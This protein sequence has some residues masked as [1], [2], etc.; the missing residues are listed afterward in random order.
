MGTR[1]AGTVGR[2]GRAQQCDRASI[3]VDDPGDGRARGGRDRAAVSGLVGGCCPGQPV[4]RGTITELERY[5]DSLSI[6]SILSRRTSRASM[7][8]KA[9]QGGCEM[10]GLLVRT[11]STAS[12]R[13]APAASGLRLRWRGGPWAP[14]TFGARQPPDTPLLGTRFATTFTGPGR[15]TGREAPHLSSTRHTDRVALDRPRLPGCHPRPPE[16]PDRRGR[17]AVVATAPGALLALTVPELRRLLTRLVWR[18]APDPAFTLAWS[19]W[20]HRHQA[21][22]R[23]CHHQRQRTKL[24]LQ[25]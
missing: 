8:R 4:G 18:L 24:Q 20:C 2:A 13:A 9:R 21:T 22:T 5:Q 16:W 3:P 23:R 12:S 10:L 19:V 6:L 1:L 11:S 17:G 14:H 7:G 15:R 25:L